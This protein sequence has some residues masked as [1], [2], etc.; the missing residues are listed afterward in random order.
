MGIGLGEILG[1]SIVVAIALSIIV[2]SVYAV[3][4]LIRKMLGR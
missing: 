4:L 1:L 3:V 2:G